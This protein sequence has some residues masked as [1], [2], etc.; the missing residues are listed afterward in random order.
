[1]YKVRKNKNDFDIYSTQKYNIED[2][3]IDKIEVILGWKDLDNSI[4]EE[5]INDYVDIL[6]NN[7]I[8]LSKNLYKR[9]CY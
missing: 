9:F 7:Y 8:S 1:M 5:L 6:N 4:K 3:D 2:E